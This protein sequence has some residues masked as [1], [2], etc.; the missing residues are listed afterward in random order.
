MT[1]NLYSLSC[2]L[3][4]VEVQTRRQSAR[5]TAPP[6]PTNTQNTDTVGGSQGTHFSTTENHLS[7]KDNHAVAVDSKNNVQVSANGCDSTDTCNKTN[8]S[9]CKT[10]TTE[11]ATS[12]FP[13]PAKSLISPKPEN[14][15]VDCRTVNVPS[16]LGNDLVE[17]VRRNT[18]ISYKKSCVAVETILGHIS[19]NIP[20]VSELMDRIYKTMSEVST[21]I[22]I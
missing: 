18:G 5:R 11:T 21:Y 1:L 7:I 9:I 2:R 15:V 3:D 4:F 13:S 12:P 14:S 22:S 16:S 19:I 6:P 8:S 17:E 10:E 20:D